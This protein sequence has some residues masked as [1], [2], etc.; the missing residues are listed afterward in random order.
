MDLKKSLIGQNV[1][2]S[3]STNVQNNLLAK[4]AVNEDTNSMRLPRILS[5][6]EFANIS[7]MI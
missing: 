4:E 3:M 7:L 6:R 2:L 5:L 1:F